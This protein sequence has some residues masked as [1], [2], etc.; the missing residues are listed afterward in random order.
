MPISRHSDKSVSELPR[1]D[2]LR[3]EASLDRRLE[4]VRDDLIAEGRGRET[5]E[6]IRGKDDDLSMNFK[7]LFEKIQAVCREKERRMYYHGTL[8]R[9]KAY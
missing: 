1:N 2:L 4:R 3:Y 7:N 6:D 8:H 5:Y 9:I